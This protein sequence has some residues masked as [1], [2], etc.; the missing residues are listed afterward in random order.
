MAPIHAILFDADGVLIFPYRFAQHLEREHGITRET[1]RPF[2]RGVF[3]E[4]LLGR[5]DLKVV[6]PPFLAQWRWAGSVDS[7]VDTWLRVED[8]ADER[9]IAAIGRLRQRG[10]VCG[11]ATSQERYRAAYMRAHMGFAEIFDRLFFSC[12]IGCQKPERAYYEHIQQA[13]QLDGECILFWDDLADN[14]A[15]A[16]KCGWQ[17]E[18]YL[19]FE[20]FAETLE[21][22]L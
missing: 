20:R 10:L 17:A 22:Y 5:A 1:T 14:V 4:C 7:F 15:A 21:R 11:L 13:L 6:L 19:G 12:E 9:L 3:D 18:Q 8:A 16:R 2:F